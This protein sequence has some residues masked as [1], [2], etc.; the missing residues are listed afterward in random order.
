MTATMLR[1]REICGSEAASQSPD[2]A[3][4]KA[5]DENEVLKAKERRGRDDYVHSTS[6][7]RGH[8]FWSG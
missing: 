7:R 8:D 6:S 3:R 2:Q 1:P 4:L 5:R